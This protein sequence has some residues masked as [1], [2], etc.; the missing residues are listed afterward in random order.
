MIDRGARL[1]VAAL[2]HRA[3]LFSGHSEGPLRR[4]D[5]DHRWRDFGI[6]LHIRAPDTENGGPTSTEA[7]A[8]RFDSWVDHN[9]DQANLQFL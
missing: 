8:F 4:A 3:Q 1:R 7:I 5:L 9:A 6:A 2:S